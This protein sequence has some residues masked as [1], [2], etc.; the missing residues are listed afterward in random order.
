[1]LRLEV[2]LQLS[3]FRAWCAWNERRRRHRKSLEAALR[4]HQN[5]VLREYLLEWCHAAH[6]RHSMRQRSSYWR[7]QRLLHHGIRN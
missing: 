3:C 6:R 4:L 1:M 5:R 7:D 2:L